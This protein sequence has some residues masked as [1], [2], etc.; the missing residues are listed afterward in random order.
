MTRPIGEI[1][2]ALAEAV[3]QVHPASYRDLA[4]HVPGVNPACRSEMERVRLTLRN[5]AA[6]GELERCGTTRVPGVSRPLTLYAPKRRGGW[7]TN[8]QALGQVLQGWLV[9]G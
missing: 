6:E 9:R 5:M 8:G 4:T 3:Q 7:V 1:R 2:Q